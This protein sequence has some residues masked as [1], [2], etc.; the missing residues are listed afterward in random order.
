MTANI[1]VLGRNGQV[2]RE[3]DRLGAPEGFQ[4]VFA[5]RENF[6][7]SAREHQL[8]AL[9]RAQ[10]VKLARNLPVSSQ[11]QDIRGH[12]ASIR[13]ALVLNASGSPMEPRRPPLR[14]RCSLETPLCARSP[15]S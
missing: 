11:H 13:F 15:S 12:T 2:A 4:L 6:D 14:L 10:P 8:E 5:G 7:L 1:L 3:L 9:G